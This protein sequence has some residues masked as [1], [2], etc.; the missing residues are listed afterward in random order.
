MIVMAVL[1]DRW[2]AGDAE[3]GPSGADAVL[4]SGRQGV[5]AHLL[6]AGGPGLLSREGNTPNE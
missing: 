5:T 6:Y 1:F 3:R 2:Q 4:R